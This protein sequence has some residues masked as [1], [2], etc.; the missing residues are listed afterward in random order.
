MITNRTGAANNN[1]K[2]VPPFIGNIQLLCPTCNLV[3][4]RKFWIQV[5]HKLKNRLT[6]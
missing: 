5:K 3:K 4:A 2:C 6:A 1:C